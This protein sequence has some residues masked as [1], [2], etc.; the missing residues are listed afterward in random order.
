[1]RTA[2]ILFLTVLAGLCVVQA[3]QVREQPNIILITLDTT[4]ADRMGFLGSRRGLTPQ[5]DAVARQ[6][7][8]FTHAYS[9]APIT[10]VSHATILTGT[11]QQ[12]HRV[13]DF[14]VPLPGSVPY[15]PDLLKA[16]GYRTAAFVGSLILDP[17]NGLAPGFDRGFDTYEAGYRI[18]QNREDRY[19]SM[20]RRAG[21][22]V[23]R[24]IAWI[25]Q[26][27]RG[28]FFAWVH[29][30]DAH[31]PYDPPAPFSRRYASAPYDGEIAYV[32]SS[33]GKLFDTLR[34]RGLCDNSLIAVMSDHGEALGQHGEQTH[35]VFLYDETIHV[36]LVLKLPH[37]RMAGRRFDPTVSLVD[38]APTLLEIAGAAVPPAM[39]G[40]SLM[41]MV[42]S[43][44]P[45]ERPAFSET[46]YPRRAFGWSPLASWRA[47]SY[48]FVGAPRREL[49]NEKSDPGAS[50][51]V[52]EGNRSLA[53]RLASQ[54]DDFR[55]RFGGERSIASEPPI[56]PK[57]VE[58]LTALGYVGAT[59]SAA[60]GSAGGIDP[61]D[62]VATANA[63]HN[64]ITSIENGRYDR[65]TPLLER[66]VATDPQIY[67]AQFQLGVARA[68]QRSYA[69]AIEPLRKA[70]EL[71]P[72]SGMAHY[73][74]GVA[75]YE[76]GDWKTAASHFEIAVLRMPKSADAHY[77]LASVYAR[78]DRVPQAVTELRTTLDLNRKHPR[79]NLLLGR[80]LTLQGQA[81]AGLPYLEQ[82]VALQPN[83]SEAH[84]FLA[85]AYAR[86]GR[87]NDAERERARAGQLKTRSRQD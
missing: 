75:L 39:Q 22:V 28:P 70:I 47:A 49:Y 36:P 76:T 16:K 56:D 3:G 37:E 18:R 44:S 10:T 17:R 50:R 62:R 46:D 59:R 12:T 9:Q 74:L 24:A 6:G 29:V 2:L 66:V 82:A 45:Q 57:I 42:A 21:D 52:A 1:M 65:A 4:R 20:E 80:I 60:A 85:D 71:L 27:G 64:A 25:E 35:G 55:R 40:Q 84:A 5:L 26:N 41:R 67:L 54:L 86:V 58:K 51:N 11:Y 53:D 38:V 79:A 14:G 31:D 30:Y 43:S 72:D 7:V 8:V 61:K 48:L 68:R 87:T 23:S 15:L 13:N 77:S 81:A 83:S 69:K 19:Q 73:E 32:D 78:T 63:L 33:M 34:A